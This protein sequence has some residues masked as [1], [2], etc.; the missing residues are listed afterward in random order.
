MLTQQNRKLE[1][2]ATS[3]LIIRSNNIIFAPVPT[4]STT[5]DTFGNTPY[6]Y[7]ITCSGS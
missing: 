1:E 3:S 7:D 2:W 5:T 4:S 6:I